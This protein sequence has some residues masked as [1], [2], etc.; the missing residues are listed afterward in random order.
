MTSKPASSPGIFSFFLPLYL[1]TFLFSLSNSLLIPV[2][3][4]YA[5]QFEVSY[6]LVGVILAADT[7]GTLISDLPAGMLMHRLGQKS[8]MIAGLLLS[9]LFTAGL[10]WAP[11]ILIAI[12][13][14]MLAG[15]GMSLF[16]V[17]RH[18]FLAEMT[19]PTER[20]RIISLYGGF[21]RLGR[22]IGPVLG[23]VIANTYG[24]RTS[25]LSFGLVCLL[26][27]AIVVYF[28]P[29]LEVDRPGESSRR[30]SPL[31]RLSAMLSGQGRALRTAGSGFLFM[32]IIRMGPIT[33][34]PLYAANVL[35][36]DAQTIGTIMSLS[37][38]LDMLLFY[39]AGMLMDRWGRKYAILSSILFLTLGNALIPFA[40]SFTGLL[41]AG[42]LAGLGNGLGSGV[43]LTL[44]SDLAPQN[45]RSEFLGAWTLI[46]DVGNTS[47]PLIIGALADYMPLAHTGWVVAAGGL[48]AAAIFA[49]CVPE[50]LKKRPV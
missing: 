2:L 31:E 3:P 17:S 25:F 7:L 43:M 1:P 12:L 35:A 22:L 32:Q 47:G 13:F 15:F 30:L 21:F 46:G 24:L 29:H 11:S 5:Q 20:G 23:G 9:G 45:G 36:M 34:I 26:A 28:L 38:T 44:G 14:R 37:S 42:L 49:L 40:G 48:L 33:L 41:T 50:T 8:S 19:P 10:Y 18:Y 16:G 39:P 4:L 6:G 27:L